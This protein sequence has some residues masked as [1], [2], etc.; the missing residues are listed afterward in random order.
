M[1]NSTFTVE[2]PEAEVDVSPML[3][4]RAVEVAN[5]IE[6]IE[7]IKTSS[8]WTVLQQKVF[9]PRLSLLLKRLRTE[10]DP[11]EMFRLQG[12]IQGI[13]LHTN[14]ATLSLSM[15]KELDGIKSKLK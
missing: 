10:K 9:D 15:R 11:T 2:T 1:N 5:I 14:L 8:Y 4:Q 12:M 6:A 13:E 7:S 3:Q